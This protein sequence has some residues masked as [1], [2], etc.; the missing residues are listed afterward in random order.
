MGRL[1]FID[2]LK[3]VFVIWMVPTHAFDGLFPYELK[4]TPLYQSIAFFNGL[5]A[6][7]FLLSSGFLAVYTFKGEKI[8]QRLRRGVE[9]MAFGYFLQM[10]TSSIPKMFVNPQSVLEGI[11]IFQR[12]DI[13]ICIGLGVI[14]LSSLLYVVRDKLKRVLLFL[15][16]AFF[17]WY[18]SPFINKFGENLPPFIAPYFSFKNSLFP[19]FP[20]WGYFFFGS[21]LASAFLLNR[22][23]FFALSL[24][25]IFALFL[26]FF[27]NFPR[28]ETSLGYILLKTGV[29]ILLIYILMGAENFG[30][31]FKPLALLGR[32]S[33]LSYAFH[34]SI[35][36]GSPFTKPL[37]Y[38]YGH[39]GW[40]KG[41]LI[42][43]LILA[44]TWVFVYSWE[45]LRKNY[46]QRPAREF[47]KFATLTVLL[48]PW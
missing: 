29:V 47:W 12:V 41:M 21:A 37:L 35:V 18:F 2:W 26:N 25:P 48:S 28:Y 20:Y 6:P 3:G 42:G 43:T 44:L 31:R 10:P 7:V 4:S 11:N 24:I 17:F 30:F 13:L 45:I 19:P 33:L 39:V 9:L 46:G 40:L 15:F 22:K 1:L 36:Y 23:I 14:V 32:N 34:N 27:L 8:Y 16:L 38:Y 5:V